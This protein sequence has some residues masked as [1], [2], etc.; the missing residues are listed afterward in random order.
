[1]SRRR[2]FKVDMVD[3]GGGEA[4]R[5]EPMNEAKSMCDEV[6]ATSF[7]TRYRVE[8]G[9][10]GVVFDGYSC[11]EARRQ[12]RIFVTRSKTNGSRLE[13]CSAISLFKDAELMR[14]FHP[15]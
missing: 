12:F 15:A 8:V 2:L 13:A 11:S 10:V 6:P 1:M 7:E 14:Q 4:A 3:T 5:S 9:G